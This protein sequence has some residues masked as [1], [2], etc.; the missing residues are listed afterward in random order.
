MVVRSIERRWYAGAIVEQADLVGVDAQ[1]VVPLHTPLR[2]ELFRAQGHV[3]SRRVEVHDDELL[4]GV[5]G[6][7]DG[8][9]HWR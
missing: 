3:L 4:A 5:G 9:F 2:Q 6:A 7:C 1:V 8:L